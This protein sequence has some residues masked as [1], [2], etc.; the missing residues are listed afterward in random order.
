MTALGQELLFAATPPHQPR[1][2][3]PGSAYGPGPGRTPASAQSR[4][5]FLAQ[6]GGAD[7]GAIGFG[8]VSHRGAQVSVGRA[9]TAGVVRNERGWIWVR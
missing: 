2:G 7:D 4:S 6:P 8:C 1:L 9:D 5:A 3:G